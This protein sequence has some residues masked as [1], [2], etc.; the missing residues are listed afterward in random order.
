MPAGK[1]LRR[2]LSRLR[3]ANQNALVP[4]FAAVCEGVGANG[5]QFGI[6]RGAKSKASNAPWTAVSAATMADMKDLAIDDLQLFA[7]VAALGSLS[8]LPAEGYWRTNDAGLAANRVLAAFTD[9]QPVPIFA[10]TASTR[11]RLPKIKACLDYWAQ[12]FDTSAQASTP[13]KTL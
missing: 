9:P 7:R 1:V 10:V 4:A 2:L 12:W 6:A 3:V 5:P 11:Q 8:A 13:Q